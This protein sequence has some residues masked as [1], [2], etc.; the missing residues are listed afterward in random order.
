[1]P[2]GGGEEDSVNFKSHTQTTFNFPLTLTYVLADDTGS[3]VLTDLLNKCGI[4]S[5]TKSDIT[6]DYKIVVSGSCYVGNYDVAD[7]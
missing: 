2:L 5:S 1:M 3:T 6:V 7:C 4:T